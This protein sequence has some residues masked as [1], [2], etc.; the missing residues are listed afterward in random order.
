MKDRLDQYSMAQFIDIACGDY[1]HIDADA[2]TARQIAGNL[3]DKYN[4]AA[5]TVST[6]SRLLEGEK[7]GKNDSKIKFYRILLNIINVYDAYDDVRDILKTAGLGNIANRGDESLKAKIEQMLR[8]EECLYER[9]M[10]ERKGDLKGNVSEDELRAS[11]DH[12]T[13][14]L[15]AHFKFTINHET[16]S[17][18]VYASLVNMACKQQR[19]QASK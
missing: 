6:M 17:A 13:A 18:S 9:M 14:R 5:D 12:Q 3:I 7:A 1:T 15:M 4:N 16:I 10:Q 19:Q 2:E 8:T 11:F